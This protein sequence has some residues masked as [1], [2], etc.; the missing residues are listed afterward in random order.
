MF[1]GAVLVAHNGTIIYENALESEDFTTGEKL[2]PI[3]V[4]SIGSVTKQFTAMAILILKEQG[5]LTLD[6]ISNPDVF[7]FLIEMDSVSFESGEK[8]SYT[9]NG[10]VILSMIIEKVSGVPFYQFMATNIFEPL[11]MNNTLV[12]N[13]TK[14]KIQNKTIGYNEYGDLDGSNILTAGDGGI[15]STIEDLFK[16]D[17]ALY[18]KN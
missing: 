15:Y 14:P 8:C 6:D 9:N 3:S 4:F 10:Y 18:S 13:N 12:W 1:N 11:E 5:K 7:N 17:Q 16:F 2:S